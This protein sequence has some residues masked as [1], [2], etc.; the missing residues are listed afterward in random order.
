MR[1]PPAVATLA[2]SGAA[3][4]LIVM[5]TDGVIRYWG[6]GPVGLM[7]VAGL[8]T[9]AL[10]AAPRAAG[11]VGLGAAAASGA[12][13]AG[14]PW[15]LPGVAARGVGSP[16][17]LA[18][19]AAT[20]AFAG[21]APLRAALGRA[22]AGGVAL[23]V[24]VAA[25]LHGSG[26]SAL[27][28]AVYLLGTGTALATDPVQG[29]LAPP[30]RGSSSL[31]WIAV[32][33]V[34]LVLLG[35]SLVRAP[36]DPSP[37]P[38]L[39]GLA[40]GFVTAALVRGR[41]GALLAVAGVAALAAAGRAGPAEVLELLGPAA[42]LWTAVG[43]GGVAG[44]SC[45]ALGLARATGP[46]LLGAAVVVGMV[47][48]RL[49][50]RLGRVASG[51]AAT[52]AGDPLGLGRLAARREAAVLRHASVGVHGAV[53]LWQA[54]ERVFVELDGT[55][56]DPGTRTGAAERLA[57]T[58]AAAATPG[59]A[60]ARVAGDDLGLATG[61]LRAQAFL[62][63]DVA[64]PSAPLAR[65]QALAVPELGD[66]WLHPGVRL[67][68]RPA[69]AVARLGERADVVVE[70][71]RVG[72]TDA[73]RTLPDAAAVRASLRSLRPAGVYV[74]ALG[75]PTV[76]PAR[77]HRVLDAVARA[78][79]QATA[80]YPPDGADTALVVVPASPRPLAWAGF[81]RAVAADL[82]A[83]SR[84]SI[85]EAVD[86][87]G[88]VWAPLPS[89]SRVAPS[90]LTLPAE[91][92]RPGPLPLLDLPGSGFDPAPLFDAA[93]PAV[94]LRERH[95]AL[96]RFAEVLRAAASGQVTRSVDLARELSRSPAGA[97]AVEPLVRPHLD[98]ARA[99]MRRAEQEGGGG[100]SWSEA[101]AA[102]ATARLV[103]PGF[104]ETLCAEAELAER[105]GAAADAEA[106]W[107][108]CLEADPRSLAALDGLARLRRARGDLLGA[109]A[110]LREAT[111][112]HADTW[113]THHNLGVFLL[114]VGRADEAERELRQAV[115][116][117][118]EAAAPSS[119]PD[120][121]L[122]RLYLASGRPALALAS[123]NRAA[124]LDPGA[125][126]LFLR[127]AS[128]YELGQ[129]D[130]AEADFLAALERD[131]RYALARGGLGQVQAARG[132][133]ALAAESFRAVLAVDP[134]NAAARANLD[135]LAPLLRP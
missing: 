134:E 130:L 28:P 82:E 39:A 68:E 66:T 22:G 77:F 61:A 100:R 98:R 74:L 8:A 67:L 17:M 71:A 32:L 132:Q 129:L 62:R 73:R 21:A 76:D 127:G 123:A 103:H 94:R 6:S 33:P 37:A 44:A 43:L 1:V 11:L 42:G 5:L 116:L 52:L 29:R 54:D 117:Q 25:I 106:R 91:P 7:G 90:P 49:D 121:A 99:A 93:A 19:V 85:R 118:G 55:V 115:V 2:A 122:T 20:L 56:A 57:G 109:E 14:A 51:S 63:V 89:P 125:E 124:T 87:A 9:L 35:W 114:A 31:A 64:V 111:L 12:L 40:T 92:G 108:R 119:A 110:A 34:A 24:G 78:A 13:V 38:T 81:E 15:I 102:L 58:L 84:W 45:G 23:G 135:R 50:T 95:Q 131:P 79:P 27:A 69:A 88:L 59:R 104:P 47:L 48:P 36:L 65:A 126:T 112:G 80:W 97:R 30:R 107:A 53:A 120:R 41:P 18:V 4:G 75:S 86:L 70:I 46:V 10:A 60:L 101:E 3:G 133:Y 96:D 72:W 26:L 113:T 16:G 128:R 105:R 83:L